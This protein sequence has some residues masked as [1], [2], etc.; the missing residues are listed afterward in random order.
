MQVKEMSQNNNRPPTPANSNAPQQKISY[1][2]E[3][4]EELI[5]DVLRVYPTLTR[6]EAEEILHAYGAL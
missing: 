5:Q 2:L 1:G 3:S 6:E 4:R